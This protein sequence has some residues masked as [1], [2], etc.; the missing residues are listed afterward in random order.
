[1]VD[2]VFISSDFFLQAFPKMSVECHMINKVINNLRS[3]FCNKDYH[4]IMN[5]KNNFITLIK[6]IK[7]LIVSALNNEGPHAKKQTESLLK[8]EETVFNFITEIQNFILKYGLNNDKVQEQIEKKNPYHKKKTK[9]LI[10]LEEY[11]NENDIEKK[12]EKEKV[13]EKIIED[14]LVIFSEFLNSRRK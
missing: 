2:S 14:I 4:P 6:T 12:E 11:E 3:I 1:M 9:K 7:A 8:D 10:N 5:D 13:N